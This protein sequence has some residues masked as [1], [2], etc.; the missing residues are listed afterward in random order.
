MTSSFSKSYALGCIDMLIF[1]PCYDYLDGSNLILTLD[2]PLS[3]LQFSKI[4]NSS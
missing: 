2:D 3:S 4:S 1:L